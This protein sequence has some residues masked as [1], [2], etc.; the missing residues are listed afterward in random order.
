MKKRQKKLLGLAAGITG[1][2]LVYLVA[3]QASDQLGSWKYV[4][5]GAAVLL[6]AGITMLRERAGRRGE[7]EGAEDPTEQ[8][9]VALQQRDE[10]LQQLARQLD[11]REQSLANK[12]VT[13]HEWMEFPEPVDLNELPGDQ[14][15][16]ELGELVEK[17][18]QVIELLESETERIFNAILENQFVRDGDFQ[19]QL[20]RDEVFELANRVARIYH[21]DPAAKWPL[22]ETSAEQIMVATS[23]AAMQLLVVIDQLPLNVKQMNIR[24]MYSYVSRAVQAYGVYKAARPYLSF[25]SGAYYVGRFALGSNPAALGAWWILQ[26][27]GKRATDAITNRFLNRQALGLL[28][29]LVRAV[30]FEVAQIYGGDFRHRD[31]NWIFAAE[32]AEVVATLPPTA[33]SLAQALQETGLLQLRSE[34]DRI[35]LYRMMAAG[36]SCQPGQYQAATLLGVEK[37]EEIAGRLQQF[38]DNCYGEVDLGQR[39]RWRD[40]LNARLQVTVRTQDG[41]FGEA[42]EQLAAAVTALAHFLVHHKHADPAEMVTRL[43]TLPLVSQLAEGD[44]EQLLSSFIPSPS[45]EAPVLEPGAAW[46]ELFVDSLVD[47]QVNHTPRGPADP[48]V[49]A[50]GPHLGVSRDEMR[51]RLD[52]AYLDVLQQVSSKDL[53]GS[54]PA[55]MASLVL[56]VLDPE[57]QA[58]CFHPVIELSTE[59]GEPL[60]LQRNQA[61]LVGTPARLLVLAGS[62]RQGI[63][64]QSES[65]VRLEKEG[66]W[67]KNHCCLSGG[68]LLLEPPGDPAQMRLAGELLSGYEGSFGPLAA[69]NE[70]LPPDQ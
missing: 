66:G 49:V 7:G 24:S 46:T 33:E 6:L 58:A 54:L 32:L 10:S 35:Y 55:G 37:R 64:W 43:S 38:V 69:L 56:D 18:H 45:F 70:K 40:E 17:D 68:Q 62:H 1:M 42:Q 36:R 15:R 61:W 47:L 3:W 67:L 5:Y 27:V 19:P 14:E 26:K 31:A 39:T 30:G 8:L 65:R 28:H 13:F 60:S 2:L 63:V 25:A 59:A 9:E 41:G 53:P 11:R 12:L 34:Y 16:E 57:E 52:R 51:Q 20:L 48:V 21:P 22:L 29:S 50:T 23:R 44:L 4:L